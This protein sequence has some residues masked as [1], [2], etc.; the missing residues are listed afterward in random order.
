MF[1]SSNLI[2]LTKGKLLLGT[3]EES[4]SDIAVENPVDKIAKS[5]ASIHYSNDVGGVPSEIAKV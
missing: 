2:A 5:L 4:C 1:L 3:S